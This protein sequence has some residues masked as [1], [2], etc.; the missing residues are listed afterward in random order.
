MSVQYFQNGDKD[1]YI[2]KKILQNLSGIS[3]GTIPVPTTP[4][5]VGAPTTQTDVTVAT[6]GTA[7]QAIAA[8]SK[9]YIAAAVGNTGLLY[10][11]DANVTNASGTKK[12]F[13]LSQAGLSPLLSG[14]VYVNADNNGDLAGVTTI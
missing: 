2:L 9:G 4:G 8:G 3:D 11:G 7:V 14:P 12:G 10:V 6:A 5:S 13:I 1:W